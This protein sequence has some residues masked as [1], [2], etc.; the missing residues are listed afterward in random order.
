MLSLEDFGIE[1]V[2]GMLEKHH[3]VFRSQGGM[4]YSLNLIQ[5]PSSFHKG[6]QGPHNNREIDLLFKRY[7]QDELF[8]LFQEEQYT[9][10]QIVRLVSPHNKKSKDI[11]SKQFNK[12]KNYG[13]KYKKNDIIRRLMGGK[14]Y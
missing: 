10:E 11:L 14:L 12:V 4:D 13:G 5:L 3:I 1:A 9:F 2:P 8:Y 6:S 7:L